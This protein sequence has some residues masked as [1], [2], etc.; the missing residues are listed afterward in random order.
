MIPL[1]AGFYTTPIAKKPVLF[2]WSKNTR[3]FSTDVSV[4]QACYVTIIL[5]A[6]I[7]GRRLAFERTSRCSHNFLILFFSP[8]LLHQHT[9]DQQPICRQQSLLRP[10]TFLPFLKFARDQPISPQPGSPEEAA[11]FEHPS[12]SQKSLQPKPDIKPGK[13]V[14]WFIGVTEPVNITL[15]L[16]PVKDKHDPFFDSAEMERGSTRT[17]ISR[18]NTTISGRSLGRLQKNNSSL[19]MLSIFCSNVPIYY[20]RGML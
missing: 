1:A 8:I 2:P 9:T 19:S 17:L 5:V 4:D 14:S 10:S 16:S 11:G 20:A 7:R 12:T 6:I 18:E 3:Y 15:I 13:L